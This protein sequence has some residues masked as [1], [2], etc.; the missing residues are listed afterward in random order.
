MD[1]CGLSRAFVAVACIGTP[2]RAVRAV[3]MDRLW[4]ILGM[5]V[6]DEMHGVR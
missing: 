1:R 4:P 6:E 3:R 5:E 2:Y